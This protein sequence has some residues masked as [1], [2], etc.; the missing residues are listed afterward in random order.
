MGTGVIVH[1]AVRKGEEDVSANYAITYRNGLLTVRSKKSQAITAADVT[2][3]YGD[4]DK[5]VSATTDGGGAISYAVKEGSGE[6]IDVDA[7]TGA[8]T[9]RKVP[10]DGRAYVTVTASETFE[11]DIQYAQATKDVIVTI[12]KAASRVGTAP[13]ANS[14]T[15]N[16]E[17]QELVTAGTAIGGTMLYSLDGKAFSKEIPTATDAGAYTVWYKVAGDANHNDTVSQSVKST[18]AQA[19]ISKAVVTLAKASYGYDG[20]A[21]RPK[22]ESVTLNGDK[23]KASDYTV[24]YASNTKPGTAIVTVTGKGNY[25]GSANATF[26]IKLGKAKITASANIKKK[27]VAAKW[28]KVKGAEKYQVQW[29]A[30][31]GK[32]KAKTVKST[33]ATVKGLKV[34]KAY[35]VRVRALFG[36]SKGDWSTQGRCWLAKQVGVKATSKKPGIVKVS[37]K[38]TVKAGLKAGRAYKVKVK[39]T[40]AGGKH[41]EKA[42]RTVTLTVKVK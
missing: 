38:V 1:T 6:Y 14:L 29:R 41:F 26:A 8:L 23:L 7:A 13:G 5:A 28:S 30:Q 18:V 25:K 12:S 17:A 39:V 20:N 24:G 33:K 11:G 36:K 42:T 40:A 9:V 21:K 15:Y 32:W 37:G 34:G 4:R 3:V 16:G 35:D 22:V 10:A 27:T 31:G 19:D 2:A